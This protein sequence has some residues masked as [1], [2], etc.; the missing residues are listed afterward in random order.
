MTFHTRSGLGAEITDEELRAVGRASLAD[1]VILDLRCYGKDKNI[2]DAWEWMKPRPGIDAPTR[3]L[4]LATL[5]P[6][7]RA[8]RAMLPKLRH[9]DPRRAFTAAACS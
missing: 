9:A 5:F 8:T 6:K 1:Q 7:Q 2:F 4:V 3:A